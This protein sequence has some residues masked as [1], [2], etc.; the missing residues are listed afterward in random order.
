MATNTTNGADPAAGGDRT[1]S[2]AM[3]VPPSFHRM[4]SWYPY[5]NLDAQML[6]AYSNWQKGAGAFTNN[7]APIYQN[8][9]AQPGAVGGGLLGKSAYSGGANPFGSYGP[10]AG[11]QYYGRGNGLLGGA[12]GGGG[13]GG[14]PPSGPPGSLPPPPPPGTPLTRNPFEWTG[15]PVTNPWGPNP[16]TRTSRT[17]TPTPWEP[18]GRTSRTGTPTGIDPSSRASA[19]VGVPGVAAGGA[20]LPY[21]PGAQFDPG[22][23]NT[24][25]ASMLAHFNSL[26][27]NQRGNYINAIDQYSLGKGG[28]NNLG[29]ALQQALRAQQG[30]SVFDNWYA[31]NVTNKQG[32]SIGREGLPSWLVSALGG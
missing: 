25:V 4:G 7:A 18:G 29:A 5:A 23:G 30:Q 12:P 2:G 21:T 15:A 32:S 9:R 13:G 22:S 11:S 31:S 26:P 24:S 16:Y 1:G 3:W 17:G 8:M 19:P 27:E 10:S 6:D 28:A 20:T 14:G